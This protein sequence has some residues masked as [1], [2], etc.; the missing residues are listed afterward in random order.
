MPSKEYE[1]YKK[2]QDE[3]FKDI[4]FKKI[5]K[6]LGEYLEKTKKKMKEREE[7]LLKT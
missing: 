3:M 1:I 7:I 4:D 6:S 5:G 2:I